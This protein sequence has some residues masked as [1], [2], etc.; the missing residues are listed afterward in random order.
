[1][2][3]TNS[4]IQSEDCGAIAA[5]PG[6]LKVHSY[7]PLETRFNRAYG[8]GSCQTDRVS[9]AVPYQPGSAVKIRFGYVER[10][11]DPWGYLQVM[12]P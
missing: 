6:P 8:I 9:T 3:F 2:A 10:G 5:R 12:N 7:R 1:M 4:T 11:W